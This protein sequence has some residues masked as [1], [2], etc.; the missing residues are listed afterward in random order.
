MRKSILVALMFLF[1]TLAFA[2]SVPAPEFENRPYLLKDNTLT[3]LERKDAS[4][5]Q[6]SKAFGY[7]GAEIHYTVFSPASTTRITTSSLPKF[8][9]KV[10]QGVD[11]TESFS[12]VKAVIKKGKRSFVAAGFGL[13]GKAK[14]VSKSRINVSYNKISDGMYE[15]TLPETIEKG[16]YGF[17]P[18]SFDAMKTGNSLKVACFGVD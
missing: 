16:E 1:G 6:K 4:F 3:E 15:I 8:I 11:P 18:T 2:Q 5:E 12:V 7:G 13:G 17:L 10:D 9:V 14:D